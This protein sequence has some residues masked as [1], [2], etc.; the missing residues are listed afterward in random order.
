MISYERIIINELKR[1]DQWYY[2]IPPSFKKLTVIKC[3]LTKTKK[4]EY[5]RLGV[6]RINNI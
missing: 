4:F 5:I 3:E 2:Y 1:I 6:K